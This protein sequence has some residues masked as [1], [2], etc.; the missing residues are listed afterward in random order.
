MTHLRLISPLVAIT[1]LTI[2]IAST[3]ITP[4]ASSSQPHN[5]FQPSKLPH[6]NHIFNA[7]HSAMRQWGSSVNHNGMS[8]FHATIPEHVQ[9]YHGDSRAEPVRGMQWMAFEPE[10]AELFV[11]RENMGS[12]AGK[13]ARDGNATME[14]VEFF[15][16]EVRYGNSSER[17]K[18][19]MGGWLHDYRTTRALRVLYLDG[20]SAANSKKG[21][22]DLQD[23]VLLNQESENSIISDMDRAARMCKLFQ[24]RA[25]G[26]IDG[27]IRMEGGFEAILCHSEDVLEPIRIKQS[28]PPAGDPPGLNA[29]ADS[30]FEYYRA[31]ASRYFGVG[32]GRVIVDFE[33]MVSGY[34]YLAEG[35]DHSKMRRIR[36][37]L[38]YAGTNLREAAMKLLLQ[39]PQE[40]EHHDWQG[41]AD[42][43]VSRYATPLGLLAGLT[44]P[45]SFRKGL[46]AVTEPFYSLQNSQVDVAVAVERCAMQ[47]IPTRYD[48]V[49]AANAIIAVSAAIC[50]N[51]V[52]A[53][54]E[55]ND[56]VSMEIIQAL[57]AY[58]NWPSWRF[59]KGCQPEEICWT[60]IWPLGGL[61][62]KLNPRC[63]GEAPN[64]LEMSY[65]R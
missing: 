56:T 14:E 48:D 31:V 3:L 17:L 11:K 42:M 23:I 13:I 40:M 38:P 30:A 19:R 32:G 4:A 41:V 22:V 26:N 18:E 6:A 7:V 16:E 61:H 39:E 1:H 43:I 58:L 63:I 52:H 24:T 20:M 53:S 36:D 54:A 27:V 45:L 8:I 25:H 65:W 9:L 64:P 46:E 55:D 15:Q 50:Q 47:D 21:T 44:D 51:L 28:K 2:L 34:A 12:F 57:V 37:I 29:N 5:C 33:S 49:L 62:D 60:P 35:P 59:C 10:H